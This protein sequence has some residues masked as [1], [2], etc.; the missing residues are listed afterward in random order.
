MEY[1]EEKI[2]KVV[3]DYYKNK[4]LSNQE[5]SNRMRAINM[6][7]IK[8]LPMSEAIYWLSKYENDY[9]EDAE[10]RNKLKA[11]YRAQLNA[12]LKKLGLKSTKE[13]LMTI[14]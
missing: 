1:S 9:F 14:D 13:G 2:Y 3:S 10:T 11:R 12:I 6:L 8:E 4:G 7:V 5:F